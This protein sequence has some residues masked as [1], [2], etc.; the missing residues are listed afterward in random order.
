MISEFVASD[1]L[2]GTILNFRALHMLLDVLQGQLRAETNFAGNRGDSILRSGQQVSVG[3]SS[4][5]LKLAA[6]ISAQHCESVGINYPIKLLDQLQ[7]A[8]S[9]G[10]HCGNPCSVALRLQILP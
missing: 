1:L 8:L 3:E 2:N 9:A 7:S 5:A 10:D 4:V 6:Q